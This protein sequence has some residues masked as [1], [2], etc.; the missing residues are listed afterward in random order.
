MIPDFEMFEIELEYETAR[1]NIWQRDGMPFTELFIYVHKI[2]EMNGGFCRITF[3]LWR[4][5]RFFM[6]QLLT[7]P[8][9]RHMTNA[10][11]IEAVMAEFRN[12]VKDSAYARLLKD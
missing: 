12:L 4:S 11:Q 3:R 9:S 1:F 5:S 2:E 10:D 6:A 8:Y 7:S